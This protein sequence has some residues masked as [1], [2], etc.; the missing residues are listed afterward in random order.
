[1]FLWTAGSLFPGASKQAIVTEPT[2]ENNGS[3]PNSTMNARFS[4]DAETD[5][6]IHRNSARIDIYSCSEIS[7][8]RIL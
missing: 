8:K 4:A 5:D 3:V 7:G 6:G 1:M 2:E